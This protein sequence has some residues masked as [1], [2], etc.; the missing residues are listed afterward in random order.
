MERT[1]KAGEFYRH[2]KNNLYQI[3]TVAKHSET[4]EELVI[5]QALYGDYGVYARPLEMFLSEVDHDKYP[6]VEQTYRFEKVELGKRKGQSENSDVASSA[7]D[8]SG[9]K[10]ED[11]TD[12]SGL[13]VSSET[14]SQE[15]QPDPKLLEFLDADT[16]EE[17][18]N[19]LVSMGECIT[20]K[21]IDDIAV[22]MDIVIPE[23]DLMNRYDDLKHAVRT[24][25]R[26]EYSN[27]LR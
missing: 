24:R 9:H 4:G 25:Q 23:G 16:F 21:L 5:Y 19:V 14:E 1:P 26:Y 6:L 11:D 3:V 13:S 15:A 7:G 8:M 17:K 12:I 2:F 27:R 22:V 20:D 10:V 18:Y